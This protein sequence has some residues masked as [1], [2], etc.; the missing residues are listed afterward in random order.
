MK[1]F[2]AMG[3]E[4]YEA[5]VILGVFHDRESAEKRIEECRL[6]YEYFYSEYEIDEWE[7]K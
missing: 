3:I 6:D 1:V 7:V 4:P 5:D 2:I